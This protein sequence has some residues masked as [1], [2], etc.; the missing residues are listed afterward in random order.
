MEECVQV[1]TTAGS[2]DEAQRIARALVEER[3]AACVQVAAVT[4]RYRWQGDV[5]QAEEFALAIKT[6]AARVAAVQDRIRA[7]HSYAMPEIIVMP[8]IGGD[9]GYLAWIGENSAAE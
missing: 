3:L 6:T 5:E 8:I 2:P 9:A 4:S 7:L 1:G